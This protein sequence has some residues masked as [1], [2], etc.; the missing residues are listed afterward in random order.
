MKYTAKTIKKK[1]LSKKDPG[2]SSSR[3]DS[4]SKGRL[5]TTVS[6][7]ETPLLAR[8]NEPTPAGSAPLS[9][10]WPA[11]VRERGDF[12]HRA[13]LFP[14]SVK[15]WR[16]RLVERVLAEPHRF[17]KVPTGASIETV[18]ALVDEGI[19][20]IREV[21][22][23]L[24]LV[25]ET[26]RLGNKS[27]PVDELVYII[28]SRKTREGAYQHG[29]EALKARFSRW[30]ELL[31]APREEVTRLVW[32][33]GLADKK[34]ESLYGA[35]GRLKESF[36]SC[37]LEP[38]RSWP[39]E[40]VEDFLCTLPEI[41]RKSAYCVMMYAMDRQVL[42]V[43]THVGRVLARIAPF[44]EL[45]LDLSG[46]DHKQLQAVLADLVPPNI[47]YAL[48]VNLLAHGR[49]VCK[50]PQPVCSECEVRK[51]CAF[52]RAE[53][54]AR[55]EASD[56]PTV[57]DLFSGAGGLSEGF[58]RAGFRILAA[59]DMDEVALKTH[60]LNHPAIPEENILVGDIRELKPETLRRIVGRRRLD[61][62]IGAPPCQ[63]FS[64][65]GHRSK[66]SKTGYRTIQDQR[67][68]LF[69][70]LVALALDL[71][72]RLFLMENVP[73]MGTA[74][75][76]DL[77]FLEMAKKRLEAGK[78]T[79]EVWDLNAV[80]FGVPQERARTFLVAASDE[81]LPHRPRGDYQNKR[82]SDLDTDALPPV[83]LGEAIFDLPPL[84]ATSGNGV[85][86]WDRAVDPKDV[87]YRR[88]LSK[89]GLVD[90]QSALIFNH[91]SR[92]NNERDLELY[93]LLD[94]GED[95]VHAIERHGRA[96]LMR[97]RR[98]VFDDK[99]D[100]LVERAPSKTIVA[101]LAKDGNGYIHP[102]QVRS[103]TPREAARL[104][105]FQDGYAF[106]GSPSDQWVQIGNAVPPV[107]SQ[108]IARSFLHTLRSKK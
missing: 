36:G 53:E 89:F 4:G 84:E 51:F 77:S 102:T 41:S 64:M 87:R 5:K 37:T 100:R 83:T 21:S 27:D 90:H 43:D 97:Y 10:G 22:R 59:G 52:Y 107:L 72:P 28:L 33:G 56:A 61:V 35:L 88:Y 63:G 79:A 60:R 32:A 40:Q 95:S 55:A 101:H 71:R 18:R 39:D 19:A 99:Y 8:A 91:A 85:D 16:E 78:Y 94:Q 58:H 96:D 69:E 54:V 67:N 81:H 49:A 15:E 25:Y 103:I 46:L 76:N 74:K 31:D 48:H 108:A 34:T 3:R 29:Y 13:R 106:C 68:Y 92:Y 26:P 17:P 57:I 70:W 24:E 2:D 20:F 82:Q 11:D 6:E 9:E 65:A 45:G 14:P 98:D 50:S 38:T 44:R 30:E 73:G 105:S 80:A 62:L 1:L 7:E 23:L 12:Y 47:R 75:K 93:A 104:Q 42:P 86:R 66:N